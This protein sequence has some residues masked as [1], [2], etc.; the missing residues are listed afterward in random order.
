[1][2]THPELD[3]I[4]IYETRGVSVI[5]VDSIVRIEASSNYSKV[6]LSCGKTI[7]VSK[8][9]KQMEELL[10]G[11]GFA[12]IHRSHLVNTNWIKTYNFNH[13]HIMLNNKEQLRISRRKGVGIRKSLGEWSFT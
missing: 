7:I 13:L 10:A 6:L 5:P 2:Q 9:L 8:V 11:K 3:S 4:L 12:R 1:M